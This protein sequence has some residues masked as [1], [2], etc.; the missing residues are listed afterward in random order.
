MV[1]TNVHLQAE[2]LPSIYELGKFLRAHQLHLEPI[3]VAVE[4]MCL[5]RSEGQTALT[6]RL[7]DP[8]EGAITYLLAKERLRAALLDKPEHYPSELTQTLDAYVQLAGRIDHQIGLLDSHLEKNLYQQD[9]GAFLDA[10]LH[11][12]V[13]MMEDQSSLQKEVYFYLDRISPSVTTRSRPAQRVLMAFRPLLL[14]GDDLL[15]AVRHGQ[16]REVRQA[17][18]QFEAHV[19]RLRLQQGKWVDQLSTSQQE[20]L[21]RHWDGLMH[22]S[23]NWLS[24]VDQFLTGS[25][26]PPSYESLGWAYYGYHHYLKSAFDGG[27]GSL[28]G[29]Y[30][31]LLEDLGRLAVP[32]SGTL[33]WLKLIKPAEAVGLESSEDHTLDGAE[34]Q[35]LVF[36]VDVSSSMQAR[37]RLPLFREALATLTEELRPQD[38]VSI[39]TFSGEAKEILPPTSGDQRNRILQVR[40]EL[41]GQGKTVILPG[42]Q[43]AYASAG[44]HGGMGKNNSV[45]MV[46]DGE[47]DI[48]EE[49]VALVEAQA[50]QGIHLSILAVGELEPRMQ[51]RLNKLAE[52]G[53]GHLGR[54]TPARTSNQLIEEV[55]A[56]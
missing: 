22:A 27:K 16:L 46:T 19:S 29:R 13:I 3:Q 20:I 17:R 6:W 31:L 7:A 48:S 55:L 40:D 42:F 52:I 38:Y 37:G 25:K 14:R 33:P 32:R 53:Q 1:S 41:N 15:R 2:Q 39:V 21:L 43:M 12:L 44:K 47:F 50:Y 10:A 18:S 26:V 9:Q 45:L 4:T 8:S 28:V 49:L 11:R 54:L 35:N 24:V 23:E 30:N 51:Y 36:L 34:Y 56:D 5:E